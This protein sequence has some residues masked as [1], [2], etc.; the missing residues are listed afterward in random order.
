MN[1]F[2]S[3]L[4]E[5]KIVI[6]DE[7]NHPGWVKI[8]PF[9]TRYLTDNTGKVIGREISEFKISAD[10]RM[11]P[12]FID[13]QGVAGPIYIAKYLAGFS[14]GSLVNKSGITPYAQTPVNWHNQLQELNASD[15]LYRYTV[16]TVWTRQLLQDLIAIEFA[17]TDMSNIIPGNP[18]ITTTGS[19]D[20]LSYHTGV[21]ANN[22]GDHNVSF[23]YRGLEDI[24]RGGTSAYVQGIQNS[25]GWLKVTT[26][27]YF[28]VSLD[29]WEQ[30]NYRPG[31]GVRYIVSYTNEIVDDKYNITIPS[32]TS[33]SKTD[34]YVD[35][36][37][38]DQNNDK[39]AY[40]S[41]GGGEYDISHGLWSMNYVNNESTKL[42][43][44]LVRRYKDNRITSLTPEEE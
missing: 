36:I 25:N 32:K 41:C 38:N 11:N 44:R 5:Q 23:K 15:E 22:N 1:D 17:R 8:N 21:N 13:E 18:K 33:S 4:L 42:Y 28:P 43:G 12:M 39:T 19:T 10:Y 20:T 2:D 27:D 14:N 24:W 31:S 7:V 9:Y 30:L 35:Q 29:N 16:E 37:Y 40:T 3:T 26:Y 34:I 6:E